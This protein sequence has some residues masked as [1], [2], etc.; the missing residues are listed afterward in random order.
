M[1]TPSGIPRLP[2]ARIA[3]W[4]AIALACAW[5]VGF[6]AGLLVRILTPL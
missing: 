3:V 4:L 6:A 5:G 1:Q 2:W